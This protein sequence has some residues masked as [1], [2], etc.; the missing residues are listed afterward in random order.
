MWRKEYA[1][2]HDKG[3]ATPPPPPPPPPPAPL[4]EEEEEEEEEGAEGISACARHSLTLPSTAH[5]AH[6][7]PPPA[8]APV[9]FASAVALADEDEDRSDAEL[10]A[11][12]HG[13]KASAVTLCGPWGR[14]T[15]APRR[16]WLL[17]AS[18][19]KNLRL[20]S[21]S[22]PSPALTPEP[23]RTSTVAS[24]VVLTP[25]PPPQSKY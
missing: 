6:T 14:S 16:Y 7:A 23:R 9:A 21:A 18:H 1:Q 11:G 20:V 5:V 4:E 2:V 10:A 24:S 13:A 12:G 8:A 19:W 3:G 17:A 25:P 15:W 22:G